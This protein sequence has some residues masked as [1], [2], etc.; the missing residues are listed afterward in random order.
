[1]YIHI[2]TDL[3]NRFGRNVVHCCRIV[4]IK[5][6]CLS[7][8]C[9]RV[10]LCAHVYSCVRGVTCQNAVLVERNWLTVCKSVCV[11]FVYEKMFVFMISKT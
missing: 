4:A 10:F 6:Y 11:W 8:I 3:A 9:L 5:F 7:Q 2:H 1:M